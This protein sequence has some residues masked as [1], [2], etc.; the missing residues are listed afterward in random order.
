MV[1]I[2]GKITFKNVC[3]SYNK[4]NTTL[5]NINLEI[6]PKSSLA[7]VGQSGVGKTTC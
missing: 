2:N 7:I 5:E 3:Y 1:E 6:E 4:D